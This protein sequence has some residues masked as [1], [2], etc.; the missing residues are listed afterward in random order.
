MA[1]TFTRSENKTEAYYVG[2][3]NSCGY[4]DKDLKK[5]VI[6]IVNSF[7]DVNPGHKVFYDLVK[8]VKEGIWC[9]G[10]C[11]AEFCVPAPCDGMAQGEGMHSILPIRDLIAS[12][13]E[14]MVNAHRFD[15]LVFPL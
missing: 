11:P 9:A 10:G 12:S 15:G 8:Y 2:L 3:M 14:A 6:G 7:T 1:E 4:R 5:P 13:I